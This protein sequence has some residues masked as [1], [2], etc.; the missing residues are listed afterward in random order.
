MGLLN[1]KNIADIG[2]EIRTNKFNVK[3]LKSGDVL[4]L[5]DG[6]AAIAIYL[7]DINWT[8]N[9]YKGIIISESGTMLCAEKSSISTFSGLM[10]NNYRENGII[11]LSIHDLDIIEI[12]P[13]LCESEIY[14]DPRRL[15]KY[16][17]D[18]TEKNISRIKRK[19]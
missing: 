8:D 4:Y 6:T 3:D 7:K 17:N 5:R 19:Q 9:L 12:S 1:K 16:L 10:L 18:L 14:K 11:Y 2:K 15:W 13:G